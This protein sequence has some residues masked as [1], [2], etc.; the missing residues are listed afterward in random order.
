[1]GIEM[2][3]TKTTTVAVI[4]HALQEDARGRHMG[5]RG[6]LAIETVADDV[7]D[8]LGAGGDG[9]ADR[10][11]EATAGDLGGAWG[12]RRRGC[13]GRAVGHG[14]VPVRYIETST[15]LVVYVGR[16]MDSNC[17]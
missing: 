12:R 15:R 2:T 1:M 17:V 11:A 3:T 5:P 10:A 8:G 16:W 4:T 6:L 14:R 9:E 13:S 7:V